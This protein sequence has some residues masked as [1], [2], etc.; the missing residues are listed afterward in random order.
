MLA[1][2][3]HPRVRLN[4]ICPYFTMFPLFFPYRVLRTARQSDIVYDPFCGRGTTNFAAR[5]LGLSTFGVDS[6]PVAYAIAQAKLVTAKAEEIRERCRDILSKHRPSS[7]PNGEFWSLAYHPDT[8]EQIC[9]IRDYLLAKQQPDHIEIALQAL[10][11]GILHGPRMK[12]QDTYLSNQMP[13]TFSSKPDYSVRYWKKH[14]LLPIR[15]DVTNLIYRKASYTYN[16][17][18]PATVDGKIILADSR[19]VSTISPEKFDW[20]VTSPPYFG[21]ATY[22]QD[23]WLRNWFMGG[24]DVVDYRT[25]NQVKH[26]SEISFTQDLSIAWANTA[27]KCK[28]GAALVCRF[29]ALPSK[30]KRKSKVFHRQS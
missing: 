20:V 1:N 25:K 21:M 28:P 7:I 22:E 13:R 2:K 17:Q 6:N 3:M 10:L 12:I 26:G 23:Q 8:L 24:L 30:C 18:I 11:L 15:Q 19:S 27:Q 9:T 29:G 4:A 14:A 16:E 5:L